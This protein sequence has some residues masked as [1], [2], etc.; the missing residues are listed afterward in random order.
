MSPALAILCYHRVLGEAER[1]GGRPY[2]ERGTAVSRTNFAAQMSAVRAHFDVWSEADVLAWR[3]G[4]RELTRPACWLTFDDGYRDV[5]DAAAPTLAALELP[6]TVFVTTAL[7]DDRSRWL[8]ADL[9]YAAL[10][11]AT[12]TRGVIRGVD[13]EAVPFD[14]ARNRDRWVD[15]PERRR[16]LRASPPEQ[17]RLIGEFAEAL[18]LASLPPPDLYLTPADLLDLVR[19]RWTVGGHG[20][21]HAILSEVRG[22]DLMREVTAPRDALLALGLDPQVFAYPDGASD[23]SIADATRGVGWAAAVALGRRQ[24]TRDDDDFALPRF[25][26]ADDLEWVERRLLPAMGG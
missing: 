22:D 23:A 24:A 2:F 21:T 25:V 4:G 1:A 7:H 26:P 13:G 14:L 5:V 17:L 11:R 3:R 9:W 16:Y 20:H 19:A 6:A 10:A 12:R 18:G 8:P 15:G